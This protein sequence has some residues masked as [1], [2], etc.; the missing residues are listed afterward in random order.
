MKTNL[1]QIKILQ[2]MHVGNIALYPLLY[3]DP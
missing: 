1:F 2:A 3:C